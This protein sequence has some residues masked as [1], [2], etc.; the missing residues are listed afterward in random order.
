MRTE[1]AETI[2]KS[3]ARDCREVFAQR[4]GLFDA[5][6]LE[7]LLEQWHARPTRRTGLRA[8][9]QGGYVRAPACDRVG[10]FALGDV[11]AGTDLRRGG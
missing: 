1:V 9:L 8:A 7:Q 4:L 6:G 10:E 2:S 3:S 5:L 11:V